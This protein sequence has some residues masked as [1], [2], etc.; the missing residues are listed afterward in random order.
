MSDE[1]ESTPCGRV[2]GAWR[3]S[4]SGSH[5]LTPAG[6]RRLVRPGRPAATGHG[7]VAAHRPGGRL[8]LVGWH[9]FAR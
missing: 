3:R 1:S 7:P 6:R 4:G 9:L 8:G 5:S 2:I